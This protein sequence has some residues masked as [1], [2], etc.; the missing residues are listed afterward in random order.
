[1]KSIC[2]KKTLVERQYSQKKNNKYLKVGLIVDSKFSN[3]PRFYLD[4]AA[5]VYR[6]YKRSFFSKD[7]KVQLF[8][9]RIINSLRLR[10]FKITVFFK[11]MIDSET[12]GLNF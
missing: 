5:D 3:D 6:A 2:L 9:I 4:F 12:S 8:F 11:V 10:T 7:C 1:M